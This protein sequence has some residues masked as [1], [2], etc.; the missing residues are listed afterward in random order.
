MLPYQQ[1][2]KLRGCQTLIYNK[3]NVKAAFP[4]TSLRFEGKKKQQI[5]NQQPNNGEIKTQIAKHK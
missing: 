5:Y 4:V 3:G 2:I 1:M